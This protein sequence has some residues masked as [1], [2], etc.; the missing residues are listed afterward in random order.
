MAAQK[1]KRKHQNLRHEGSGILRT[2]GFGVLLL[3]FWA[4]IR[5]LRTAEG[6]ILRTEGH[7]F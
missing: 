7:G 5:Y 2:E 1:R 3:R 6:D 4:A